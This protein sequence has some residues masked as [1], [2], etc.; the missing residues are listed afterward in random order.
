MDPSQ[1]PDLSITANRRVSLTVPNAQRRNFVNTFQTRATAIT[2]ATIDLA[3]LPMRRSCRSFSDDLLVGIGLLTHYVSSNGKLG[4]KLR[5][6]VM[7]SWSADHTLL[8]WLNDELAAGELMIGYEL[9]DRVVPFLS[10]RAKTGDFP[11]LRR[12]TS[13]GA[14]GVFDLTEPGPP[15]RTI[16]FELA[17]ADAGIPMP[18]GEWRI[19]HDGRQPSFNP[20]VEKRLG[21]YAVASW[22]LWAKRHGE[23][24]DGRGLLAD[25]LPSVDRW[26]WNSVNRQPR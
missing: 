23:R 7:Q 11:H 9:V 14:D 12:L 25:V 4:L 26:L 17:C 19:G 15:G 1:L 8:Q 16:S 24:L 13:P 5:C 3:A 21:M 22:R 20:A 10:E 18:I 6:R 2:I